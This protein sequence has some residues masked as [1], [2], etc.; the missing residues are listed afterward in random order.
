MEDIRK[1][2]TIG[3]NVTIYPNTV[4]NARDGKG[5]VIFDRGQ[6]IKQEGVT[7]SSGLQFGY[8]NENRDIRGFLIR[9]NAKHWV[10]FRRPR[11]HSVDE[12]QWIPAEAKATIWNGVTNNFDTQ[13][14]NRDI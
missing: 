3:F 6:R 4:Y 13:G 9:R 14:V 10:L 2:T 11:C 7:I 12:R 1:E 8:V 5:D